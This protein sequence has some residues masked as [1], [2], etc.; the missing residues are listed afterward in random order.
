[1]EGILRKANTDTYAYLKIIITSIPFKAMVAMFDVNIINITNRQTNKQKKPKIPHFKFNEYR[2][3]VIVRTRIEYF[4]LI[5]YCP[6]QLPWDVTS[7]RLKP[8]FDL[9]FF[10]DLYIPLQFV[11]HIQLILT[12]A[13]WIS[14]TYLWIS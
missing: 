1:M 4:N 11:W 10:N 8:C 6:F 7:Y 14:D 3:L 5:I 9:I 2:Y 13:Y 12:N